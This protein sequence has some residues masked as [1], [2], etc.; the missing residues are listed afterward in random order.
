M[1][2]A[3]EYT[4]PSSSTIYTTTTTLTS[5]TTTT[6]TA[7]APSTHTNTHSRFL[8]KNSRELIKRFQP[9]WS[10]SIHWV[11]RGSTITIGQYIDS[12]T[13]DTSYRET[14]VCS[15]SSSDGSSGGEEDSL[16]TSSPLPTSDL[17]RVPSTASLT[18]DIHT[19]LPTLPP[20]T[21]HATLTY[22][23]YKDGKELTPP[24]YTHSYYTIRKARRKD[25][26]HYICVMVSPGDR[27]E[28]VIIVDTY[29]QTSGTI[30]YIYNA[31]MY[32]CCFYSCYI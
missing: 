14:P 17:T 29:V 9:S 10:K 30:L 4:A 23:W 5:P 22:Q 18:A 8:Y 2:N 20:H 1:S 7:A 21:H 32:T 27:S 16:C 11:T 15:F 12:T 26:G 31:M 13:F 19:T 6:N 25:S 24:D 28:D 3:P